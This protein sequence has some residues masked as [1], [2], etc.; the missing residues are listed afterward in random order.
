[1]YTMK[2]KVKTFRRG[3]QLQL[4]VPKL[5]YIFNHV[6]INYRNNF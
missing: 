5:S 6:K 3:A 2:C 4:N 1:M